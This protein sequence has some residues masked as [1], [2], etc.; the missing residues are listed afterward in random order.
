MDL[1]NKTVTQMSAV[2]KSLTPAA[3]M[4]VVLLA[5]MIVASFGYLV[6]Q[7]VSPA[8]SY[9][10]GG[11]MFSSAQLREMQ[12]AF[13]QAGLEA[14]VEGARVL[15]PSGQESKYMAA[16]AEAHAL[17]VDFGGYLD[18]AV[19]PSGFMPVFRSQQDATLRVAKQQELQ[20][21]IR[22]MRGIEKAAVQID[23]TRSNDFPREKNIVTAGVMVKSKGNEPLDDDTAR[24]I[25]QMVASSVAGLKPEAITVVDLNS[26][27]SL[28]GTGGDSSAGNS[29]NDDFDYKR[30]Q[31][32]QWQQKISHVLEYI[33]G[34][35]VSTTVELD[36]EVEHEEMSVEYGDRGGADGIRVSKA[37]AG[38]GATQKHI[39]R[40]GRT[41]RHVQVSVAVPQP[42]YDDVWRKEN[43]TLPG[44]QSRKPDAA[45]MSALVNRE[46][47]KIES[48]VSNL[49]PV[50]SDT[51]ATRDRVAI[52]TFH[53]LERAPF[54]DT[55]DWREVALSWGAQHGGSVAL[56]GLGLV[57][58]IVLRSMLRTGLA[59][60][61]A[62]AAGHTTSNDEALSFTRL[63]D[64]EPLA[65]PHT[66][67]GRRAAPVGPVFQGELADMVREDPNA[68]ASVLR[69]WIGNAS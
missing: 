29:A 31:E 40:Q 32:T 6:N 8:D 63:D 35:L 27:R 25:R 65:G 26:H 41:V 16:L 9:L 34:V 24:T 53:P 5:V 55:F 33:P 38:Q 23:Q 51:A 13:G 43:P 68:A 4:M 66:R 12:A 11:E 57:G 45:A 14:R 3:R 28:A 56:A 7:K 42:Y 46:M 2:F 52:S 64:A 44:R 18:K 20:N 19:N 10:M 21:I 58:L 50:P 49:L 54:E 36:P 1:L 60:P 17:P 39:V 22:N 67:R 30:R 61:P 15:V 62:A 69:T 48:L 37:T 59:A 47:Q